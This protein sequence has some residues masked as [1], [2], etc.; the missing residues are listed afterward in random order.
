MKKKGFLIIYF[1][2]FLFPFSVFAGERKEVTLNKCVD[3]DTAYFNVGKEKK[4]ARFLAIDTP[5][6]VHPNKKVEPYGKE[7]SSYTCSKLTNASKI[8]IEYDDGSNKEDRY[9]RILVWVYTDSKL[10]QKDLVSKG[11]AKVA[12]LYGD[13]QYT[14]IL[15]A[16]EKKAK[17]KKLRIWS[18]EVMTDNEKSTKDAKGSIKK[19]T[20]SKNNDIFDEILA[21]ITRKLVK[22]LENML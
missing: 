15:Q 1:C 11:Y 13:Y 16:E 10:L 18:D 3:G 6:S 21:K 4:K 19:S 22:T 2:I 8:E 9:G 14:N 7:A 17:E 12:Y 20:K 5:E